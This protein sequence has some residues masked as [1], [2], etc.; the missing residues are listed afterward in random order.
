MSDRVPDQ[1]QL[2]PN[3]KLTG[4]FLLSYKQT[5]RCLFLSFTVNVS[6]HPV[7]LFL[8][9]YMAVAA[10]FSRVTFRTL[11]NLPVQMGHST[12]RSLQ[13][14]QMLCPFS[15]ILIGDAMY[16]AQTGHSSNSKICQ[17]RCLPDIFCVVLW[18]SVATPHHQRQKQN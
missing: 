18:I 1:Q 15:H 2:T 8:H 6:S 14:Q 16:S 13:L 17:S 9:G 3:I 7:F 5:E 11:I 10:K 4:H 12:R